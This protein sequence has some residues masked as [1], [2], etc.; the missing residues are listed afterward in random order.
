MAS[1]R[2]RTAA[3][4]SA[5][6]TLAALATVLALALAAAAPAAAAGWA[7]PF[8]FAPPVALDLIPPRI[9]F[10]AAGPAAIGYGVQD[11]DNPVS[12]NALTTAWSSSG[13]LGRPRQIRGA[14]EILDLA[15]DG[16]NL[17]LMAGTSEK[18]QPCCS[19]AEALRSSGAG[20]GKPRR[21][22]GGLAGPT[23]GRLVPLPGGGLLGAIA[24]ER[25]V[26]VAQ[27]STT[28]RGTGP[29]SAARRLSAAGA[30]PEALDATSL[31]N[32]KTFVVW[33]A[34]SGDFAPGPATIFAAA[35]STKAAPRSARATITVPPGHRIDELAI[36]AGPSVP[37]VAWIESWFDSAG[38][39][40]SRAVVADLRSRPRGRPI[41]S[42]SELASGLSFAADARG[43]QAL[44]WKACTTAGDCTLRAVA[45]RARGR[46]TAVVQLPAIDASQGASV[47]VSPKGQALLAWVQQGHVYATQ[48]SAGSPRFSRAHLVS[49]TGFAAD[50][51]VAF[52][53][54]SQALAAWVQG[55]MNQILVGAVF[56]TG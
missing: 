37:T 17:E 22:V 7:R 32:G 55:T 40:H 41:S 9:A 21:L 23:A 52:G 3:P 47:A 48:A 28:K 46:F 51:T 50:L 31:S 43:D 8:R 38:A 39:F 1:A 20:F 27:A 30:L 2:A 24:T 44:S 13:P 45:R 19:S 54:G 26:W 53:P 56:T 15:Y 33:T 29:F 6:V 5:R 49:N 42:A 14:Q 12:S 36:A 25:G 18:G 11:A 34:R 16:S 10:S 4:A 35:G